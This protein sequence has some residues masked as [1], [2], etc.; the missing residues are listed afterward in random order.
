MKVKDIMTARSLKCCSLDTTLLE[1]T[2]IMKESNC[3]ALPVVDENKKVLGIITD[4]DI[5]LSM[6]KKNVDSFS[7]LTVGH[8]MKSK[9]H[10][11]HIDDDI[12]TVFRLMRI[13]Q[14]GRL[15]V[16]DE[17]DKLKGIVSLHNII[18]KLITNG[19]NELVD[20][21][22]SGE[23]LIKTIQAV[24]NRNDTK[25]TKKSSSEKKSKEIDLK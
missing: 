21:S 13:N 4:R 19:N 12:S 24:S 23:N 3:G 20:L 8:I 6:A 22:Y 25:K 14:I 15:P 11:V 10:T 9:I 18:N 5:C 1:I 17:N 2:K 7:D 16:V